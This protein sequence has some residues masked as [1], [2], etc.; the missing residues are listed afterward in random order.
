MQKHQIILVGSRLESELL[1]V[2]EFRP[3][4]VHLFYTQS[5]AL[6]YKSLLDS[7]P[8][9]LV[10]NEYEIDPYAMESVGLLCAT[11]KES[12]QWDD[13]LEYNLTEGTKPSALACL[14]IALRHKDNAYYL[15]QEGE[16]INLLTHERY[17]L[18]QSLT[19]EEFVVLYGNVLASYNKASDLTEGEIKTA[20]AI[21][22]FMEEH[23]KVFQHIQ[24]QYR[25]EF[26]GRVEKLPQ[27][28]QVDRE[29]NMFLSMNAGTM[30]IEDRGKLIFNGK[31][32]STVFQF[33]TGR[34]W[35][36]VVSFYVYKW[37]LERRSDSQ[38][39]RNVEFT[40]RGS[41]HTKNE[42]DILVNDRNRL[43]LIEC[44]SGYLGQENIYKIDSTRQ[45]YGGRNS[46]GLLVTYYPL[47][48]NLRQKCEDLHI[49]NYSPPTEAARVS[50]IQNIGKWLDEVVRELESK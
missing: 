16:V 17:F 24:K 19:N 12:L 41:T 37:D 49:Y 45:T 9:N 20:F 42:L 40:S 7:F 48:E 30:K 38:V 14:A 22:H 21:K 1:L 43:I 34:W 50:Y 23:Q 29:H 39:W 31:D 11:I 27:S 36:V 15:S 10:V 13:V 47:D 33:F 5:V 25:S 4:V 46:K 18:N 32:P 26:G 35:E 2:K 44:K 8:K 3:D 6:H 28:F